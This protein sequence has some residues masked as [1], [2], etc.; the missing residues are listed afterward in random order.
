MLSLKGEEGGT[1]SDGDIS[2]QAASSRVDA[3]LDFE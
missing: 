1:H 3:E 2:G